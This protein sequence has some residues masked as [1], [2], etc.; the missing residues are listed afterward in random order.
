MVKKL[1]LKNISNLIFFNLQKKLSYRKKFTDRNLQTDI[2]KLK[3]E[4]YKLKTEIYQQKTKIYKT[5]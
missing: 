5:K 4:I 2:Y 1:L 3:T